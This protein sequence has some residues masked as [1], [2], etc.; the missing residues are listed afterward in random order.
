M[1]PQEVGNEGGGNLIMR[2]S[3]AQ[4]DGES[5][6]GGVKGNGVSFRL[7]VSGGL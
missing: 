5:M 2:Q 4:P 7:R 6:K 3:C 1:K